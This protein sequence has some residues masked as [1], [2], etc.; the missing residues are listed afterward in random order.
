MYSHLLPSVA[1]ERTNDMRREA[2]AATL[3]RLARGTRH[4]HHA[5][6]AARRGDARIDRAPVHP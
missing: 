4:G 3:A 1:V 6:G 2:T 5:H